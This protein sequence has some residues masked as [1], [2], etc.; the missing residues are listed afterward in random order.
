[1]LFKIN[2]NFVQLTLPER[3]DSL[4]LQILK[5]PLSC[6]HHVYSKSVCSLVSINQHIK[7][8]VK[9]YRKKPLC[10]HVYSN[11]FL[12]EN[13]Y[14]RRL[15]LQTPS[16]ILTDYSQDRLWTKFTGTG[17]HSHTQIK[18]FCQYKKKQ[19]D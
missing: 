17:K 1:M 12:F 5:L 4:T 10:I 16:L 11:T 14:A 19:H 6:L 8:S 3:D 13:R 15:E 18:E 9:R 7:I 2:L